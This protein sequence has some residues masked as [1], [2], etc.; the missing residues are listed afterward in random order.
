MLEVILREDIKSLGKAGEMVRVKP[1]YAR[2]YCCP[3]AWP[4]RR[5]T[6]TRNGS[7]PSPGP[8]TPS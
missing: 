4:M 1:G 2:N 5:L 8:G 7:R 3:R 6:A